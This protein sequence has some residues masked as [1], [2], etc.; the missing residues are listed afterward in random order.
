MILWLD[1]SKS[2]KDNDK[3][4]SKNGGIHQGENSLVIPIILRIYNILI[5]Y[6]FHY[7]YNHKMTYLLK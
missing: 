5:Y 6:Q 1:S 4:N 3:E 2:P 7:N